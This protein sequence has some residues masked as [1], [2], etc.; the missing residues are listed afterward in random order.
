MKKTS[1]AQD[2]LAAALLREDLED[3]GSLVDALI[4]SYTAHRGFSNDEKTFKSWLSTVSSEPRI[5]T[6]KGEWQRRIDTHLIQWQ[7]AVT[8]SYNEIHSP[9]THT[10]ASSPVASPSVRP[11]SDADMHKAALATERNLDGVHALLGNQRQPAIQAFTDAIEILIDI[12]S[13]NP[14]SQIADDL[15]T[16]YSNRADAWLMGGLVADAP[17]ALLDATKA[18]ILDPSCSRA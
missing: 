4:D 18:E 17:I 15:A 7:K 5:R 2:V 10:S 14:E 12:W 13:R 6:I 16:S 1:E 9:S 11:I 8:R 3:D